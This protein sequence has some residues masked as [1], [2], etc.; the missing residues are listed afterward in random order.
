VKAA[1]KQQAAS[2]P[3]TEQI[4]LA[5]ERAILA[6]LDATLELAIR[7]LRAEHPAL[8]PDGKVA[9]DSNYEPHDLELLPTVES[10]ALG[11]IQLRQLIA[12]FHAAVEALLRRADY[13]FPF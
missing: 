10:L 7:S 4:M 1:Q 9:T 8:G 11:A 3:S 6:A 5:P 13:G 2:L 12:H